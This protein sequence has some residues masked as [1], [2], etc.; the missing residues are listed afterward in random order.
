MFRESRGG[1]KREYGDSSLKTAKYY[2]GRAK[3]SE[4]KNTNKKGSVKSNRIFLQS[5]KVTAFQL[6]L[7][8]KN[9]HGSVTPNR[10]ATETLRKPK[11]AKTD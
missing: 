3:Y 7:G 2:F 1:P 10:M 8:C 9:H 5:C 6:F 11:M 4:R